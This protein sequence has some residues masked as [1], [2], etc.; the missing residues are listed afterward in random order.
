M[1]LK[2]LQYTLIYLIVPKTMFD[3]P[4]IKYY[5]TLKSRKSV[6]IAD[7]NLLPELL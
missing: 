5:Q 1:P 7:R 4:Q 3:L 2:V 6:C